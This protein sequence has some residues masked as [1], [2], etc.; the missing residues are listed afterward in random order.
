ME[1]DNE[2]YEDNQDLESERESEDS[3]DDNEEDEEFQIV[4]SMRKE[5]SLFHFLFT[6]YLLKHDIHVI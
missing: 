2:V 3:Q 6:I 1:E 4:Q 5:I